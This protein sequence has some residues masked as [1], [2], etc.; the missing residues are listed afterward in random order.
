[1]KKFLNDTATQVVLWIVSIFLV[2]VLMTS[3]SDDRSGHMIDGTA[4]F[5]VREATYN[6]S[7]NHY[8]AWSTIEIRSLDSSYRAGDTITIKTTSGNSYLVLYERIK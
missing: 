7:T 6:P 4:K 5:R 3:C 2:A 8:V 1:M